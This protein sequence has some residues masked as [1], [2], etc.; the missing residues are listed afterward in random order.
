MSSTF[1]KKL[2]QERDEARADTRL[3]ARFLSYRMN[4][5][6]ADESTMLLTVEDWERMVARPVP[7][8]EGRPHFAYDLGAG[9]AWSAAVAIW[10][11]GRVEALAVAPGIPDLV[12]QERR[13]RV[14]AGTYRRLAEMGSLRVAEGL[15]VQPPDA[16]HRASVAAW[17][18]PEG[19]LCDRFELN[20]LKDAVTAR[21]SRRASGD[22]AKGL[23]IFW[24]CGGWRPMGRLRSRKAA[25]HCWPR[26]CPWRS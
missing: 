2:L 11:T 10:R 5:P 6:S 24:R 26:P 7:P 3:K 13:D 9:R 17:G 12:E 15:R 22:G 20:R 19:L 1:R 14:P 25:G 16:L 8:R 18:R 23:R 21:R 4:L